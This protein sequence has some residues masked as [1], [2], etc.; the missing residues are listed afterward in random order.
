MKKQIQNTIQ[1]LTD[2]QDL[3]LSPKSW[4]SRNQINRVQ[5][6]IAENYKGLVL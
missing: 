2:Y 3:E 5:T 4:L 1:R 6:L